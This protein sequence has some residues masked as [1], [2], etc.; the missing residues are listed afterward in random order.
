MGREAGGENGAAPATS[1]PA[2][3]PFTVTFLLA[4]DSGQHM[5]D[6]IES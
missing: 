1:G 2:L 4:S 5:R 6:Q 3:S